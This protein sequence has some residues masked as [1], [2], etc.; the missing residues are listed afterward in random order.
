MGFFLKI[1]QIVGIILN[2]QIMLNLSKGIIGFLSLNSASKAY[3]IK[4]CIITTKSYTGAGTKEQQR[5]EQSPQK[6][7]WIEKQENKKQEYS[8][9]LPP[10]GFHC[11]VLILSHSKGVPNKR[12]E[13][14]RRGQNFWPNYSDRSRVSLLAEAELQTQLS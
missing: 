9:W 7:K 13:G 5:R 3:H 10:V 4:V 11:Q 1:T 2:S 14:Q 8:Q 6:R 12:D